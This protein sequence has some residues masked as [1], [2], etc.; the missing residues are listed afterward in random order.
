LS[1][2]TRERFL[3]SEILRALVKIGQIRPDLLGKA[4]YRVITL[5]KDQDPQV[6]GQAVILLGHLRVA[7][8]KG[9]LEGLL[10]DRC[11][12]EVYKEGVLEK[13]TVGNLAYE[14]LKR[15]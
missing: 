5:L 3:L 15:L 13:R 9:N 12:V 4:S 8:A 14:S 10:D 7:E 2:L 1:L 6:R 11:E